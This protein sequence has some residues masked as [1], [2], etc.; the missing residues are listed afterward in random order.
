MEKCK[1][2]KSKPRN[3][4]LVMNVLEHHALKA[5]LCLVCYRKKNVFCP[6]CWF[7]SESKEEPLRSTIFLS[8]TEHNLHIDEAEDAAYLDRQ[9]ITIHVNTLPSFRS[10]SEPLPKVSLKPEYNVEY[11]HFLV[12]SKLDEGCCRGP[13]LAEPVM[14]VLP[15][16]DRLYILDETVE[17]S[18]GDRADHLPGQISLKSLLLDELET[19]M[20]L[21]VQKSMPRATMRL[22]WDRFLSNNI[23][24][25][26]L[27]K[28]E[29]TQKW[30]RG[31]YVFK[32]ETEKRLPFSC[33]FITSDD[34]RIYL[35]RMKG[36]GDYVQ[37]QLLTL[38]ASS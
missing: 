15:L 14:L 12:R 22:I 17:Y 29:A 20:L 3:L 33:S 26:I 11:L 25:P 34:L 10:M 28:I 8:N 2:S 27:P 1:M 7:P 30:S 16:L 4:I 32:R 9:V 36:I 18:M 37:Q 24:A 31:S 13:A 35:T 38:Y 6:A 5:R 19:M 23:A 21:A